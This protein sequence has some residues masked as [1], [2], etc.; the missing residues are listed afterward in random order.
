VFDVL[1]TQFDAVREAAE[2]GL[3][4]PL[5]LPPMIPPPPPSSSGAAG[6]GAGNKGL[7]ASF[8]D[9][10]GRQA[11]HLFLLLSAFLMPARY[12]LLLFLAH[13]STQT[14]RLTTPS[15]VD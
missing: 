2:R 8:K 1:N 9:N 5:S 10:E 6:S 11:S 14:H 7:N 3:P 13:G 12:I 4:P 15:E